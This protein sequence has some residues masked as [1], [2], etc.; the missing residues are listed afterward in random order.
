M[1]ANECAY[2][3][4]NGWHTATHF[5]SS[6]TVLL[7]SFMLLICR[8]KKKQTLGMHFVYSTQFNVSRIN[9][10]LRLQ[11]Y[12]RFLPTVSC[13]KKKNSFHRLRVIRTVLFL[14]WTF[15]FPIRRVGN[16]IFLLI[17]LE[18]I[19]D[20]GYLFGWFVMHPRKRYFGWYLQPHRFNVRPYL[21]AL[22]YFKSLAVIFS[23]S[24]LNLNIAFKCISTAFIQM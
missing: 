3:E 13:A 23:R 20:N 7:I 10:K 4:W 6:Y 12:L 14:A 11:A 21:C 1:E 16:H 2:S 22:Q 9:F 5:H 19:I 24:L 8:S 17:L 18:Y 15:S